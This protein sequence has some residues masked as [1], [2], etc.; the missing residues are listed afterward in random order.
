[1]K[2]LIIAVLC[3][4]M[5]LELNAGD[6]VRFMPAWLPQAQFAGY[7]AAFENG[8]FEEEGLDVE[9]VHVFVKRCGTVPSG[10]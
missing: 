5:C 10:W 3:A 7:Y 2:R 1:M 4:I 6:K 9:I 8:F